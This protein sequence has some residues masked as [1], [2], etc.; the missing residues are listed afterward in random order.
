VAPAV[1]SFKAETRRLQRAGQPLN[2]EG[3]DGTSGGMEARTAKVQ[4]ALEHIGRETTD[5]K[6]A[7]RTLREHARADFRILFGAVVAVALGLA[8][9]MLKGF[10]CI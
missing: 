2:L 6:L 4:A 10:H 1:S 7:V 9:L 8:A 3:A 5:I